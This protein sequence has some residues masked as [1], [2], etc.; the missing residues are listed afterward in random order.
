LPLK[1]LAFH[2]LFTFSTIKIALILVGNVKK[3]GDGDKII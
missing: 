2:K 1:A 3:R